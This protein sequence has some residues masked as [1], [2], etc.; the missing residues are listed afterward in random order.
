MAKKV[1]APTTTG[2]QVNELIIKSRLSNDE[3]TR[4]VLGNVRDRFALPQGAV[5]ISESVNDLRYRDAQGFT[6]IIQRVGDANSPD[7]GR[8]KELSTDRPAVLPLTDQIPGLSGALQSALGAVNR[9]FGTTGLAGLSPEDAAALDAISR[10]ERAQLEQQ[11]ERTQGEL[12]TQL[13][14]QGINRS[15][16]AN[17]AGA[18]FAQALGIALG[19][20]ESNAA[21]RNL[22]LRKFLTQFGLETGRTGSDFINAI[23]GQ[24]T[25]RA[26]TSAQIG[27]GREGLEQSSQ[28]AARNFLLEFDKFKAS[29]NRSKLPGILSSIASLA[30]AFIPGIGPAISGAIGGIGGGLNNIRGQEAA[31]K[32]GFLTGG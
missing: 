18:D 3:A 19:Q 21:Q 4:R 5:I 16:I 31:F 27:L 1:K 25:A 26:G 13:F 22:D 30:T 8:V 28:E 24:E 11:S 15:T 32:G 12:V 29:Q 14:G 20:Q 10:N 2:Q 17:Q 23:T 7:F 6:H 9:T